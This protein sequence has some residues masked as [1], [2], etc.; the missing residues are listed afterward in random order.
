MD[1][2]LETCIFYKVLRITHSEC[3]TFLTANQIG[4]ETIFAETIDELT[5]GLMNSL[6]KPPCPSCTY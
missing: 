5:S 2:N 1:I 6:R 3:Q 4:N